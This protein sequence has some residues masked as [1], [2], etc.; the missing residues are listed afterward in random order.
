MIGDLKFFKFQKPAFVVIFSALL[1]LEGLAWGDPLMELTPPPPYQAPPYIE[2]SVE[3]PNSSRL[4][5]REDG[6]IL[7]R[8]TGL[9][10]TQKDSYAD[11]HKCLTWPEAF[12]YVENLTT[13]EYSDWRMPTMKELFSIYDNTQENVMAWDH[14]PDYPLALDAKFSDGAAYWYWSNEC[15]ETKLTEH[16]AKSLYFVRGH[17]S[18]RHFDQCNNGGVRAVRDMEKK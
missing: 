6:T 17:S 2:P 15:G 1:I 8:K 5:D 7:D 3:T 11:L 10:W 16:C 4:I 12:Q 18:L 14:N 9:L 13:G